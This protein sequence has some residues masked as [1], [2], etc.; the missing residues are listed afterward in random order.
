MHL[1]LRLEANTV[2]RINR[3]GYLP[4]TK[5]LLITALIHNRAKSLLLQYSYYTPNTPILFFIPLGTEHIKQMAFIQLLLLLCIFI[6]YSRAQRDRRHY[7]I[8]LGSG[9]PYPTHQ[10]IYAKRERLRGFLEGIE[11]FLIKRED[12][13]LFL[14]IPAWPFQPGFVVGFSN[15]TTYTVKGY[16]PPFI[17]IIWPTFNS[18]DDS[19]PLSYQSD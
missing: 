15:N 8:V 6:T 14:G 7:A 1:S 17:R 2:V 10:F 12:P 16:P 18:K 9:N 11:L 19:G 5:L 4:I 13:V 3:Y